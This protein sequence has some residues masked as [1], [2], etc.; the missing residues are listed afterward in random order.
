[1]SKEAPKGGIDVAAIPDKFGDL[2]LVKRL[3]PTE[4]DGAVVSILLEGSAGVW[5][6]SRAQFMELTKA[7]TEMAVAL[8]W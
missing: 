3:Q 2:L 4:H 1:M 7:M 6:G 5:V 8:V